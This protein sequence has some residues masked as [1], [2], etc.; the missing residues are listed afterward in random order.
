MDDTPAELTESS[1]A[2]IPE[3]AETRPDKTESLPPTETSGVVVNPRNDE[4]STERG[5]LDLGV[6][7]PE[8]TGVM[9]E[10]GRKTGALGSYFGCMCLPPGVYRRGEDATELMSVKGL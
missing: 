10:T 1:A 9:H 2:R 5:A 6:L 4:L 3:R 8:V 7:P